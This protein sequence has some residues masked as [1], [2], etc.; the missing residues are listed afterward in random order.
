MLI[1]GCRIGTTGYVV[2]LMLSAKVSWNLE[3]REQVGQGAGNPLLER[4]VDVVRA[5]S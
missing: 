3:G 1:E 2:L 4:C 5:R